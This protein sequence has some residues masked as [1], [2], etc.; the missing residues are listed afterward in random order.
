MTTSKFDILEKL[1]AQ[2]AARV[3]KLERDNELLELQVSGLNT[4]LKK[5]QNS[6]SEVRRLNNAREATKKKLAKLAG[7]VEHLIGVQ[8]KAL[9]AAYGITEDTAAPAAQTAPLAEIDA[10]NA[11][12]TVAAEQA[13]P[14]A[15]QIPQDPSAAAPMPAA[16]EPASETEPLPVE[17]ENPPADPP[18][19]SPAQAAEPEKATVHFAAAGEPVAPPPVM[20]PAEPV[21]EPG[22]EPD[23]QAGLAQLPDEEA[24]PDT[25]VSFNVTELEAEPGQAPEPE[26]AARPETAAPAET[27]ASE[28]EYPIEADHAKKARQPKS[29][30]P[31]AEPVEDDLPLFRD[32]GL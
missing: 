19:L 26:A 7:K 14:S 32:L 3:K 17:P 16:E 29:A 27:T 22:T 6:Q 11:A 23:E 21:R 30:K 5:F 10:P 31:T 8:E 15:E 13:D 4:E 1:V 24:V 9:R 12:L 25:A 20:Q 2:S 28:T 18:D